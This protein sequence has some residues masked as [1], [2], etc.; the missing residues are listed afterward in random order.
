MCITIR[1][2]AIKDNSLYPFISFI[3]VLI[4]IHISLNS[5]FNEHNVLQ[6]IFSSI[7][8]MLSFI[9][10]LIYLKKSRNSIYQSK[11]TH[12]TTK[13]DSNTKSLKINYEYNDKYEEVTYIN[14]S[15]FFYLSI[16]DY[17]QSLSLFT[18]A[19]FFSSNINAFFWSIDIMFLYIFSKCFL[20]ISIYRHHIISLIIFVLFD[21]YLSYVIIFGPDFNY[22][23]IVYIIINNILFSLK[24]VYAKK[25][26]DYNF[27]SHYKLCLIIGGITLIYGIITLIIETIID[28]KLDISEKYREFIDNFLDFCNKIIN[29]D[30]S[31]IIKEI[32]F[33]IL[34]II[35]SGLSNIFLYLTLSNLSPFHVLL[36]KILLCIEYNITTVILE[37]KIVSIINICIYI[38]SVFVLFFFLE[39]IQLNFCNLNMDTKDQI[40]ERSLDKTNTFISIKSINDSSSI[41]NVSG[42]NNTTSSYS[43]SRE[44]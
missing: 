25:L 26:M 16:L 3:F 10:F 37:L 29:E 14:Y 28:E 27:I 24:V 1:C 5:K 20:S 21:I 34:Y 33:I 40:Q 17:L 41:S 2:K 7:G 4:S 11:A 23:Q 19:H 9:P 8:S 13:S 31:V 36:T 38:L 39:I 35:S 30:S 44:F 43:N 12:K 15:N 42:E 22:W 6:N 18:F 32:I